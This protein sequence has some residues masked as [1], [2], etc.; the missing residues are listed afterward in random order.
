MNIV[1]EIRWW[2]DFACS[3][4]PN[5]LELPPVL[6]QALQILQLRDGHRRLQWALW[7]HPCQ[8]LDLVLLAGGGHHPQG[9]HGPG[10]SGASCLPTP[11]RCRTDSFF[12]P[13]RKLF[14]FLESS[15][16]WHK[17]LGD[18]SQVVASWSIGSLGPS[19]DGAENIEL[20][21]RCMC[22]RRSLH[23]QMGQDNSRKTSQHCLRCSLLSL[24]LVANF[25]PQHDFLSNLLQDGNTDISIQ[26][27]QVFVSRNKTRSKVSK[28]NF[29]G[30]PL[31]NSSEQ[32][33]SGGWIV[34]LVE[35]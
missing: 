20:C 2:Y 12:G 15:S 25:E 6:G 23:C 26:I 16:S 10:G 19:W 11:W 29:M 30:K 34:A 27:S 31:L 14:N 17:R 24:W 18:L 8:R 13:K 7:G 5:P 35:L 3:N 1:H 33:R 9:W 28:T 22:R 21:S 4:F 32:S